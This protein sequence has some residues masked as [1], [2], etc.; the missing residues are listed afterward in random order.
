MSVIFF[1]RECTVC[2]LHTC[3][4]CTII[5]CKRRIFTPVY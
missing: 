3:S 5:S 4:H 1:I 2:T